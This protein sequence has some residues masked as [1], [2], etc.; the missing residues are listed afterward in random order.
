MTCVVLPSNPF[1]V[2]L[3]PEGGFVTGSFSAR[4]VRN[5]N[6]FD[7]GIGVTLI[8]GDSSAVGVSS[9]FTWKFWD[10]GI[11]G[12]LVEQGTGSFGG[13]ISVPALVT[14]GGSIG[15]HSPQGS[16]VFNKFDGREDMT[17][18][19]IM[20]K[21]SNSPVPGSITARTMFQFGVNV[22][23]VAFEDFVGQENADL[24]A[25]ALVTRTIYERR[26]LTFSIDSRGIEQARVGGFESITSENEARD[27]WE[28]WSGPS[29][30][31]NIDAFVVNQLLLDGRYDGLDGDIPGP[32]SHDGRSSGTV[33]NKS[34]FIDAGGTR[35]LHVEYLGMLMAHELGHYLGL[36]HT[37]DAGNLMLPSSGTTD[38]NLSYDQYRTMIR[39]G[40]VSID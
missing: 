10:G 38:T 33:Q 8:N 32:T 11:G 40:W 7:T 35:R 25:A 4:G 37:S 22:T 18:E 34:G 2:S 30:N 9:Q 1:T 6:A 21:A 36:Q 16:G 29:T 31:N 13:S 23:Q 20:V 12:S 26:D 5:G 24:N 17:I 27:L 19:I 39:H 15:F 14:W 3:S 28:Q